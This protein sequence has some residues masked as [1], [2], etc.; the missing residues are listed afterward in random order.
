MLTQLLEQI[1][2]RIR[3]RSTPEVSLETDSQEICRPATWKDV[4][5]LAALLEEHD[6]RY[7]LVGGY[8]LNFNGLARQTGDVDILV[9]NE[10]VNNARWIE[11]L[12]KLPDGAAAELLS[13]KMHPFPVEDG[14]P[15]VIRVAD[16]FLVDVM[17][18]ACGLTYEDLEPFQRRV[19]TRYG[20][21]NVLNMEGLLMTKQGIRAKD[22]ADKQLLEMALKELSPSSDSH[23][24]KMAGRP[25]VEEP[26]PDVGYE[27]RDG[28]NEPLQPRR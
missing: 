24:E 14:E 22:V 26:A 20:V 18:V 15:G 2:K 3:V 25:F 21:I 16:E 17:P 11:A 8:A 23:I 12:S 19:P 10:P 4:F 5:N 7:V 6:V 13:E 27:I 9:A 1:R 28:E